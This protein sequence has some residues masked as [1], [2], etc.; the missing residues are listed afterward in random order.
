[1]P[2]SKSDTTNRDVEHVARRLDLYWRRTCGYQPDAGHEVTWHT[3]VGQAE[4]AIAAV[5]EL[6]NA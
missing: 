2:D 4:V 1:M 5:K 3:F 6:T